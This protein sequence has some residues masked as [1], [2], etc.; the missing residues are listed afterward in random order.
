VLAGPIAAQWIADRTTLGSV[1]VTVWTIVQW[2]IVFAIVTTA[3]G[4]VYYFAPDAEQDWVWITP[5]SV[6]AT[7]LWLVASLGFKYYIANFG[8]YT[9]TYGAIGG[10]MILML[11]FYISAVAVLVGAELNAEIEHASP[12]GKAPGEKVPG[13]KRKIGAAAARAWR[14]MRRRN[15][16]AAAHGPRPLPAPA[17]IRSPAAMASTPAP[18]LSLPCSLI[19]AGV[20]T[21]HLWLGVQALRYILRRRTRLTA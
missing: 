21:A 13:E 9:E 6:L 4:I 8:N 19:G 20:A 7:V 3:V 18:S 15:A 11:W 16:E 2:P 17:P 12:H 1:F 5:G 14:E 10:V